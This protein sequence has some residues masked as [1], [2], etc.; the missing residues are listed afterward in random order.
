MK[1]GATAFSLASRSGH[2]RVVKH[3]RDAGADREEAVGNG[4]TALIAASFHGHN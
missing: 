3:V 1:G 4:A 2:V